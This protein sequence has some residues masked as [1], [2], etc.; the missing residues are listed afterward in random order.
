MKD[1]TFI[2][3]QFSYCPLVWILH[4]KRLCKKINTLHEWT[5]RITY[6]NKTSSCNELLE[7]NNSVP[8]HHK[9]L[10]SSSN[11]NI[12][13]CFVQSLTIFLHRNIPS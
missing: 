6:G 7:K 8:I 3:S 10:T 2:T 12:Q 1:K 13:I 9:K 11:G 4:S 5:L